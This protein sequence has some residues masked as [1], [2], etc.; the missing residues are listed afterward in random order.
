MTGFALQDGQ[1]DLPSPN[2]TSSYW[3][4]SPSSTLLGHRTT[5]ELPEKVDVV[6]IGSG[7]TGAFAAREL[8]EEKGR[9]V[10]LLEAREVAWGA[11]GRNGGHCQP[12]VYGSPPHRAAFELRNYVYL[13]NFV[14]ANKIPCDWATTTGVHA[15]YTTD[16]VEIAQQNLQRLKE[17]APHLAKTATLI[18]PTTSNPTLQDLRVP[19][20]KAAVVQT[21]A[22]S[23]WPYRLVAW[24]IENLLASHSAAAFNLQTGTPALDV[25]RFGASWIVHT[26]RGQVAAES[27]LVACNGYV[28]RVLPR[29]TGLV[30]PVR[31]QVAALCPAGRKGDGALGHTYVFLA[32][33]QGEGTTAMDDYLIQAE[34]GE[35]E[36]IYGGG[37]VRGT[38]KGWAI[39]DDD[40]I[41]PVV[42]R[43]LRRNLHHVLSSTSHDSTNGSAKAAGENGGQ[44]PMPASFEWTGIMGHSADGVP[45]VGQVPPDLGGGD[46]LWVC[47]GYTGHGMPVASLSAIAV[48]DMMCGARGDDV[49]LPPEFRITDERIAR[50]RS[51]GV[52]GTE[53]AEEMIGFI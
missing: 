23:L 34:G 27:V 45:W 24:I 8:V 11:T 35:K 41:D 31:G 1:A 44:D 33:R 19:H 2:P 5:A 21:N 25:Q 42:S 17:L 15:L 46:G 36:L 16:L 39:S 7:I 28:S 6:V 47:G 26:P 51:R 37:R 52:V 48:V 38:D 22:A 9:G 20:A 4:R 29:F 14:E 32:A 13:K 53:S 10:L 49:D 50:A 18:T 43:H 40:E 12:F 30:V 3:H